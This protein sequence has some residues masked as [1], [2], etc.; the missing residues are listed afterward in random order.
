MDTRYREKFGRVC[1]PE[2]DITMTCSC[3]MS[4]RKFCT[5]HIVFLDNYTHYHP[6]EIGKTDQGS[7]V[8]AHGVVTTRP[9]LAQGKEK[10]SRVL[11]YHREF[12]DYDEAVPGRSHH[13][14]P[15]NAL[16]Q[17]GLNCED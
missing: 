10:N 15:L 7:G 11:I 12:Q 9:D 16:Y 8:P 4:M 17:T 6:R 5:L 13:G 1:L 14:V 2:N 3:D